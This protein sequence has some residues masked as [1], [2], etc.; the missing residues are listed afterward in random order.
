MTAR[1]CALGWDITVK[2]RMPQTGNTMKIKLEVILGQ[3][4]AV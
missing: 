4:L 1:A 2:A 3:Q